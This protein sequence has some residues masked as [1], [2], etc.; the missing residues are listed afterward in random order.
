MNG[1]FGFA[2]IVLR[3]IQD[4]QPDYLA[5]SFDLPGPTFRHEQYA[6]YKATRVKMPDD[7]R[8]QFPKVREVVKAL[9]IP[10]YEM[11][12]FEADDVIG[13]ITQQ[14]DSTRRPRD[15]DRHR[16]PRHAPARHAARPP[17]DDPLRGREHGHLRRRQD[18]R[19][20][21]PPARPDDRLQGAQGR[22]DRQHPGRARC[23]REDGGQAHPRVRRPRLAARPPRRGDARRSSATSCASTSTRSSWAASCR[24]SC[25]TCR[26]RSTSRPPGSATTT[27]TPSSGCSASTSSGR[28]IE[29][30][31]PMAGE[32]AEQ[33]TERPPIGGP[34][35]LRAR[36]PASPAGRRA[37]ARAGRR[38][39]RPQRASSSSASTSTRCGWPRRAG[40]G[41]DGR[42]AAGDGRPFE[43]APTTCPTALAA[44]ILDPGRIEVRGADR[45]ADLEPWLAA[46]PAVG[47]ALLARRPAAAAWDA[48]RPG[49]RRARTAGSSRRTA[50]KPPMPCAICSN[51]SARR[52]S[53]TRSS[54]SSS[55]ASRT[56]RRRAAAGRVRHPDRGLRPQRGA[57]Q[58]D[59]R[60]R[61]RREPRPD[62]AARDRAAGHRPR[63]P[64]GA[65]GDRGPRAARAAA[66][67]RSRL[68][69]LFRDIELPL[70]PVLAR[71][72]A[73]GVALDLEALAVLDR[74]FR[75]EISRLEQEIYVD[76]GHEFNL[77]SPKQLEQI[78]FFELTC[79]RASARRPAT[80]PTRR[81]SRSCAPP[82]R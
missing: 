53:G 62:P 2:S 33:R 60:R 22:P 43:P 47:V 39:Q 57:A 4:L 41:A 76:V 58:P 74:E 46:Q 50:P 75:A 72:E 77:G 7:L 23:G 66:S 1:V 38:R 18:R 80:R 11:P 79:R 70:I 34:E 12:G 48:A 30:L 14:L 81:C 29:R 63:R 40:A 15:D 24:R 13:T 35:R 78:L 82:T 36:R 8:D 9:R 17:D 64:R 10:V 67:T 37:G 73:V 71:M 42:R 19:A 61:R 26:S 21:R 54:R 68:D 25:A 3:G 28:S 65:V 16:R 5:V 59:H 20:V 44:A 69:R 45:I 49:R 51:G 31:P 27:A 6:E 56:T 52:S 55:P 32:T